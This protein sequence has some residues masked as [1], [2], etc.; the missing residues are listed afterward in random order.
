MDKENTDCQSVDIKLKIFLGLP[1][2]IHPEVQEE[3]G[4]V[5]HSQ[6]GTGQ[7]SI[8]DSEHGRSTQSPKNIA[9][10]RK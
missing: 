10:F 8:A 3:N 5:N 6:F 7:E 1:E 9:A 2:G 4:R